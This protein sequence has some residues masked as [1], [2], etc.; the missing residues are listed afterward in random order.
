V[1]LKVSKNRKEIW[2]SIFRSKMRVWQ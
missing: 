1:N 2:T